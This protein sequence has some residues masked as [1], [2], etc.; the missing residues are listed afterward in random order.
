MSTDKVYDF[1]TQNKV[2]KKGEAFIK[3]VWP[4]PLKKLEGKGPDFLDIN[5]DLL[6]IKTDTWDMEKSPN[7]FVEIWSVLPQGEKPGKRG[8]PWQALEK[9][10]TVYIY[11]FIS[12]RTYFVFRDIPKLVERLEELTKGKGYVYVRN[13]G[14]TTAGVKV[15]RKDLEDL[16]EEVKA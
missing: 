16:Y 8:G 15:K 5:G 7:F 9:G 1:K 14:Y 6:E 11:L 3:R 4:L 13:N 2:G 10:S 12:N